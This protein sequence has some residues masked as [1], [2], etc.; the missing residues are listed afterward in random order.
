MKSQQTD[1]APYSVTIHGAGGRMGRELV[2]LIPKQDAW[3]LRGAVVTAGS[4]ALGQDIGVFHG[5]PP[6]G[7]EGATT[8]QR[9]DVVVDFS[10]PPAIKALSATCAANGYALV[11]GTTGLEAAD[12]HALS[13][14]AES[15]PVLWTANTSVGVSLTAQLVR[16]AAAALPE[17]DIEIVEFHHREKQD[18]PSGTALLLGQAAAQGRGVSLDD[19]RVDGRSG[20]S[21]ARESGQIGFASV[22]GGTIPGE[23]KVMLLWN[24]ERIEVAHAAA[25]RQ[26][27]AS[28]AMLAA[29]WLLKQ[30]P[31]LYS[32]EDVLR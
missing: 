16:S 14:A 10:L 1:G 2:K 13:V 27:F 15:V 5:L 11:S 30:S 9:S 7:V 32:M 26:I 6:A 8:V 24:D 21:A 28:G 23:H 20:S 4:A 19:V 3:V 18:A 22:R 17:A 25:S 31:G 12:K 29:S